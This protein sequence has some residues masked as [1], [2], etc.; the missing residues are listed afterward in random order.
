MSEPGHNN[1]FKVVSFYTGNGS[2]AESAKRLAESC[3]VL[4]IEADIEGYPD[5]G[6]W[7]DNC[8]IKPEFIL[9][10]LNEEVDCLVWVDAD[11]TVVAYP[12][13]FEQTPVDFG[14]R[15]EPGGP[16]RTPVGREPIRL[17]DN[18]PSDMENMWF[19][20]GT[21]F[22][23]K[24]A[25]AIELVEAWLEYS[26]TMSRAWDQWSLQQAWADV[27]PVTEWLPRSYCQIESLHG[28]EG[29]VVLH[30]LASVTRKVD[31]A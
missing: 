18:W 29:A 25:D 20:S 10:K 8:N 12:R 14:V 6:S 2:Y 28:R 23:R 22:F 24:C 27:E 9:R 5:R 11:A 19:N 30:E 13:L 26:R 4:G 7:V 1:R 21:L 16:T 3:R 31:R 15:A 17:P